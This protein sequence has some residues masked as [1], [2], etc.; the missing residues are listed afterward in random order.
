MSLLRRRNDR[1]LQNV[2]GRGDNQPSVF[3]AFGSDQAVSH[4]LNLGG[5]TLHD[6][7]F[8]AIVMIKVNMESRQD[9]M[10]EF[11]LQVCQLFA[12]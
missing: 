7:H 4:F 11:V 5:R 10:M 3:H 9:F 6:D 1:G 8:Q 12:E 2:L